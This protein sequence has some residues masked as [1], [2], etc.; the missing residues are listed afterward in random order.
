V[1][2]SQNEGTT[3]SNVSSEDITAI[4]HMKVDLDACNELADSMHSEIQNRIKLQAKSDS[5]IVKQD[6]NIK[7][8]VDAN[9]KLVELKDTFEKGEKRE[10]RKNKWIKGIATGFGVVAILEAGW[11][12][13]STLLYN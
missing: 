3:A 10:K 5:I 2:T 6:Q 8:L 7:V 9:G 11:I 1:T 12:F 13:V 4:N